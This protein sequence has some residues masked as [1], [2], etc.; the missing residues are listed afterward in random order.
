[1]KKYVAFSCL[2]LTAAVMFSCAKMH[3]KDNYTII[4]MPNE[5]Q[6]KRGEFTIDKATKVVFDNDLDSASQRVVKNFA[7]ELSKVTGFD[8]KATEGGAGRNTIFFEKEDNTPAEGY[9]LDI[10][11]KDVDIKAGDSHGFFYAIQTFKQLLPAEV[12]G[13][14]TATD[15][16]WSANCVEIKDK[17]RFSYRG[18]HF[19]VAR[20]MFTV[21]EVKKHLDVMAMHKLNTLH[22]HITDDQGW[23]IEIK[24]YP[25][26]T[27]VGAWRKETAVGKMED[28]K[29]DGTPY[30]GFFTQ[31]QI[32]D[33]VAY[34]ADKQITVIPEIDMPGHM[35]AAVASYP[36]LGCTGKQCEV[37]TT[38][39]VSE[40]VLCAG[41]ENTFKFVEDVLTEV[42]E[43]FP[44]EYIHI[45]GDE[46]P[47]IRWKNCPN[48]QARIKTEGLK[49]DSTHTAE[50][51]L[52]SY[53]NNRVEKFLK[54]HG[55]KMIGWD[56]VLEGNPSQSTTVMSW[57][58]EAGGIEAAKSGHNVIMVPNVY[59]YFDYYQSMDLENEPKGIGG[60]VPMDMVYKYNPVPESLTPEEAKLIMGVQANL[61]TEYISDYA[62]AQYMI[63]P[64]VDALSEIAWTNPENKDWDG[65]LNRM[66]KNMKVYTLK[67]YN[68]AKHLLNVS[69]SF[70]INEKE[71]CLDITL[72][73]M[74]KAP[75]YYTLDG[76]Q[77]T[78]ASGTLYTGPIKLKNTA[79]LKAVSVRDGKESRIYECS[80]DFNKA[81]AKKLTLDE[82]ISV[83]YK[84]NG[85]KT[86]VD[87]QIGNQAFNTGRWIA[88]EG[89]DLSA[90]IDLGNEEEISEVCV[91]QLLDLAN[92]IFPAESFTVKVSADGTNY[93]TVSDQKF[94]LP[95]GYKGYGQERLTLDAKFEPVKARY[96]KINAASVKKG[97]K[98]HDGPGK[99]MFLFI[100]E[101][102]VK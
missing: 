61:W 69:M 72:R 24:K 33:I 86:L 82:E 79:T 18:M 102:S 47:R 98:W 27:E 35:V 15:V 85:V 66:D 70:D 84:Y 56:E 6:P 48:C 9:E 67:G 53:F 22:W 44:S 54:E 100:D 89:N 75:I 37:R 28:G 62:H 94:D 5:L 88:F 96:V 97:P 76:S 50:D 32:R 91:G 55:R 36:E 10:D 34:A 39:G 14:S 64:R 17:P 30:G 46:A 74:G 68:F 60:H 20:H 57:R 90:T 29:Y 101:I 11:K 78:A 87:G 38:W 4:P 7:E 43:L 58:G 77:P 65:F 12:Y 51:Y 40:D 23:R 21:D 49:S 45:G 19:D 3:T 93:T 41:K 81:T 42:M 25:K 59:L 99:P 52:Q 26:L 31:D 2:C 16:K 63:M 71:G 8:I 95:T 73:T 80:F 83:K 1:M 13:D 92:W